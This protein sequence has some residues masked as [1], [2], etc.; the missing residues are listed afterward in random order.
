M[1]P[2]AL[3]S[4]QSAGEE[5]RVARLVLVVACNLADAAAGNAPVARH[6]RA[7]V[8]VRAAGR[9]RQRA[10]GRSDRRQWSEDAEFTAQVERSVQQHVIWLELERAVS[11]DGVERAA[12][13]AVATLRAR[14]R[15]DG[16]FTR[17]GARAGRHGALQHAVVAAQLA[18]ADASIALLEV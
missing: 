12:E 15:R 8:C 7:V 1:R 3:Q 17:H 2:H 11:V 5:G 16:Q 13:V 18:A 14:R 6:A 9:R 4:T 10:G